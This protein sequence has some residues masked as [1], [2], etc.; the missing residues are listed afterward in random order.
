MKVFMFLLI[1]LVSGRVVAQT[2]SDTVDYEKDFRENVARHGRIAIGLKAGYSL[3]NLYG[4]E[5]AY[6]FAS[7]RTQWLGGFHAGVLV[8][9]KLR[10]SFWLKHELLFLQKGASVT[11]T[12]DIN[13]SYA[14]TLKAYYLEWH[15]LSPTFHYKG[16]QGYF[17]P[18]IGTVTAAHITRKDDSGKSYQDKS[19]F[20]DESN[21]EKE[22][23]YLQ[24]FDFGFA[25]GIEYQ[26]SFG[27]LLGAKYT[28]GL[29]DIF[30]YANSYT[31]EDTKHDK[32]NIHHRSI[33]FSVGYLFDKR[34]F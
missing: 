33:L 17:G 27:L 16:W 6:L 13:G 23:K 5:I 29:T 7:P 12:D 14:S 28:H 21:F 26:F 9:A 34:K 15:P 2:A 1:L 10:E 11:L 30:Q 3:T 24:K 18:Y 25:A 31:L 19:I 8:N 4:K 20:G 32:I 22:K